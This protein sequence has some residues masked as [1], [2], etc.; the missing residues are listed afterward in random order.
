MVSVKETFF[1]V[2]HWAWGQAK[3]RQRRALLLGFPNLL[4]AEKMLTA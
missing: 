1:R 4:Q 3:H 2:A